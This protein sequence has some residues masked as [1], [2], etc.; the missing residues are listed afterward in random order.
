MSGRRVWITG[1]SSGIGR[2]T[3]LELAG[4]GDHVFASARRSELLTELAEAADASGGRLAPVPLDVT[5]VTAARQAHARIEADGGPLDV[6]LFAAGTHA[7]VEAE[8]FTATS[9]RTLVDINLMGVANC[10]EPVMTAMIRRKRGH[11]AI[12]SSVAGYRG[13]P[14]AACYGAT[15][16]ALIN[17]AEA[18][19]FDLEKHCVTVQ[20]IDPG[21]VR[22]PLTDK[23]DFK[24][25]FLME[26]DDAA[27]RIADGL[28]SDRFEITFP[29][30]FTW[31]VKAFRCLPYALYF[32]LV[33]KA[34]TR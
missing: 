24:M 5:D 26:P 30:R 23:N 1:A 29:K 20:L 17:L 3:A 32:P 21:F 4:R 10:L 31:M 12:V 6:A 25:P 28:A 33:A 27:R 16:A 8:G 7:P 2:A 22:T 34:T 13:L 18:L 14:T 9:L 19:R 15:K 11:I